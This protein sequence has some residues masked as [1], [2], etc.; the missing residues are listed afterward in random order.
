MRSDEVQPYLYND[1]YFGLSSRITKWKEISEFE[2]K[3]GNA[4]EG[5]WEARCLYA[6]YYRHLNSEYYDKGKEFA[7]ELYSNNQDESKSDNF[8]YA[9]VDMVYC[10][11]KYGLSFQDYCIYNLQNKSEYCR[12]QFVADKL[13]YHYCDILNGKDVNA[14]MTDKYACYQA[15]KPFF[16]REVV[17]LRSH[18]DKDSFLRFLDRN[19]RFIYKPMTDHSGHGVI[20]I[21]TKDIVPEEWFET[22]V[23]EKTGVVEEL[24]VQGEVLNQLNPGAVNTCRVVAFKIGQDVHIIGATLRIGVGESIKDNAGSGG[25]Y[26]SV[27]PETGIIQSDA[28]N[29]NNQHFLYHPTTNTKIIGFQLPEWDKAKDLIK[30]MSSA[31]K[32]TT[33]IAWDIAYSDKGWCMV[34]ANENGDWSIIQSNQEKGKKRELFKLMDKYF[35]KQN[36]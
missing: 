21:N 10:L 3:L 18:E 16:K 28:K 19:E 15:Y 34:E 23:K 13:R 22:M 6:E 31:H 36:G 17:P 12:K 1:K 35:N 11:H 8:E 30:S 5:S 33:L 27:D 14:L 32:G 7:Y 29:Y 9:Y 2:E 4:A 26:A 20:L 25:I 24:I